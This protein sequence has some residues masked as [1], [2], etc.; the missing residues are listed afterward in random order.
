MRKKSDCRS[1]RFRVRT[2]PDIIVL[3][4]IY[5][6][7]SFLIFCF[8]TAY[9]AVEVKYG[10]HNQLP[11]QLYIYNWSAGLIVG[12]SILSHVLGTYP[13]GMVDIVSVSV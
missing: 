4:S 6:E 1:R 8:V 5:D 9:H 12:Y 2:Y 3:K 11:E 7:K 13:I 10:L